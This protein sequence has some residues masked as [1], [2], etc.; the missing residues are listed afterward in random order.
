MARNALLG[1]QELSRS[2]FD[3]H[4]GSRLRDV[5]DSRDKADVGT[6]MIAVSEETLH[7]ALFA[8]DAQDAVCKVC[9]K[10]VL[11]LVDERPDPNYGALGMTQQTFKCD[12]PECGNTL[13]T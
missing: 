6:A 5:L 9:G 7:A 13:V 12:C 4:Y 10:G 2:P 3:G 11:V 8:Q 1:H